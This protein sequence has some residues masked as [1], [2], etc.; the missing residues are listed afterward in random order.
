MLGVFSHKSLNSNQ[1]HVDFLSSE[2]ND[3]S[4]S[5]IKRNFACM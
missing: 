4:F 5:N 3:S 1:S 2:N